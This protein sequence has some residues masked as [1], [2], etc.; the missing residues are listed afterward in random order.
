MGA[1]T[2]RFR[3]QFVLGPAFVESLPAWK[4]MRVGKDTALSAH[5]DLNTV[6]RAL[7]GQSITLLGYLLDAEDPT[8]DDAA[9]LDRLLQLRLPTADMAGWAEHTDAL[10]GRWLLIVADGSATIMFGDPMGLRQAFY[11]D[12][13]LTKGLWCATQPGIIAEV[14]RLE[15][16]PVAVR[17]YM[18]SAAFKDWDEYI[19]PADT[20]PYR[21]VKHLLPNHFLDLRTGDCRR[22]WPNQPLPRM[23]T[24]AAVQHAAAILKGVLA[25]AANR[26]DLAQLIS[27]GWDSRLL[28]A[29]SKD[30]S[31]RVQYF[32]YARYAGS[33][34]VTLTPRLLSRL[35]LEHHLIRIPARMRDDFAEV[36]RSSVTLAHEDNGRFAQAFSDACPPGRLCITGNAAEITRVRF[37]T[38]GDDAITAQTL[39]RFTSFQYADQLEKIPFVIKAWSAWLSCLGETYDVHPLDIFYWEHWGGNF[40]AMDQAEMDIAVDT[41]T[42]FNCRRLLK[43]MLSTAE[44]CREHD[45]PQLYRAMIDILWPAVLIEPVNPPPSVWARATIMRAASRSWRRLVVEVT[46]VTVVALRLA[47]LD[48]VAR[49]GLRWL[50][51]RRR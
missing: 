2:L 8:A 16:D 17:E 23:T 36:Y 12:V 46:R 4:R 24:A 26:F 41:F 28:L 40:A 11:T 18:D 9:I 33:A 34:D 14:L 37:R 5:P 51:R 31:Q 27:A 42:P 13:S 15:M 25:S 7:D 20:S 21:Q 48:D 19:W 22:F 6:Q 10:G 47:G 49:R 32:T 3:R 38:K 30:V 35:G 45:D 50:E 44:S 1:E 39:A 29:A 43:T